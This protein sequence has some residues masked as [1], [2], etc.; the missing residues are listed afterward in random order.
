MKILDIEANVARSMAIAA[1]NDNLYS[2]SVYWWAKFLKCNLETGNPTGIRNGA[3]WI[4]ED[5]KMLMENDEKKDKKTIHQCDFVE[6]TVSELP[7]LLK[8]E[9]KEILKICKGRKVKD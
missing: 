3:D 2:H 4:L 9:R 1:V 7:E 8:D 6:V 5:L